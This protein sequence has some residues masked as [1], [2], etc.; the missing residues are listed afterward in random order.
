MKGKDTMNKRNK[1][2][3]SITGIT[4]VLLALLGLTYA[5]YLTRIEGNTN[6]NSISIT[7]ADLKLVYGDG[8]SDIVAT[9]IEPGNEISEKV[10]TVTNSGNANIQYGV[11][12]EN[13]INTFERVNE[14]GRLDVVYTLTC[15]TYNNIDVNND[16]SIKDGKTKLSDCNGVEES[17]FPKTNLKLVENYIEIEQ[18]QVY[19]L[20]VVYYEMNVDQSVDMNKLLGARIQI[21]ASTDVVDIIVKLPEGTEEYYA[22]LHSIPTKAQIVNGEAKFVGIMPGNHTLYIKNKSDNSIVGS[23]KINILKGNTSNID[24]TNISITDG[25]SQ[26]KIPITTITTD[27]EFGTI[28][29]IENPFN[30]NR[31]SLAYNILKNAIDINSDNSNG[32]AMY[33]EEPITTPG[34]GSANQIAIG[35]GEEKFTTNTSSGINNWYVY[36]SEVQVSADGYFKLKNPQIGLYSEI[37]SDVIGKYFFVVNGYSSEQEATDAIDIE[38]RYLRR[39]YEGTTST[40]LYYSTISVATE[41]SEK[42]LTSTEDNYGTTYYYRGGV[43][44][45]YLN[46]A[47]MCWRIV[48]IQGDGSI[49]IILEDQNLCSNSMDRQFS[50]GKSIYGYKLVGDIKTRD[51]FNNTTGKANNNIGLK[52]ILDNWLESSSIPQDLLKNDT[53]CFGN[54]E[55][56]YDYD[57]GLL[58]SQTP[59]TLVNSNTAFMYETY[60][61]LHGKGTDIHSSLLCNGETYSSKIGALTADEAAHAGANFYTTNYNYY[62]VNSTGYFW[63]LTPSYFI[64]KYDRVCVLRTYGDLGSIEVNISYKE[65]VRPVVTLKSQIEITEGNGTV[66]N[67]YVIKEN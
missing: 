25:T 37:A 2:I 8:N 63:L 40:M 1:I 27:L 35:L 45:N 60:R 33:A 50:I 61:N 59:E 29:Q 30:N 47:G 54:I 4:I 58:L 67:P 48:R 11:Y 46:F 28:T 3:I 19:K 23:R 21:Y 14:T 13:L 15:E 64:N 56:A 17:S 5:Y 20:K 44:N 31:S 38:S 10:F 22:E 12:L 55:E 39:F 57:T 26:I 6:A 43:E 7:T 24:G 51:F 42:I 66:D 52:E 16:G 36:S 65:P 53:W 41:N 62:L 18:T 9:N 49:K 32:L 34:K